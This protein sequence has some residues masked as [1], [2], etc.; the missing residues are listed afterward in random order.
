MMKQ[1]DS[2]SLR[3]IRKIGAAGIAG[4]IAFY[5]LL[6]GSSPLSA[7]LLKCYQLL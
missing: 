7:I 3:Q 2:I 5:A 6:R 1:M 4:D